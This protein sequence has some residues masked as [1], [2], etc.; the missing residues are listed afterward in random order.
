V[1][2]IL[3]PTLPP[4]P[5]LFSDS[6]NMSE[7]IHNIAG[8]V[9]GEDLGQD[10]VRHTRGEQ[11]VSGGSAEIAQESVHG[12][13]DGPALEADTNL[14]TILESEENEASSVQMKLIIP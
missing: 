5:D 13:H 11:A 14:A 8:L 7:R 3:A 10:D 1:L 6:E 4:L 9:E 12:V 2:D